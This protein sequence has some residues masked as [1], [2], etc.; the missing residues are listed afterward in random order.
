MPVHR[1]GAR[2]PGVARQ[3]PKQRRTTGTEYQ[4]EE[5]CLKY[6]SKATGIP[7][8]ESCALQYRTQQ[9]VLLW[10]TLRFLPM[11]EARGSREG[12]M[13]VVAEVLQ[14]TVPVYDEFVARTEALQTV[15]LR[16]RVEGF[17]EQ[18]LFQDGAIVKEGQVLCV[19]ERRPYEAALQTAKA[20]LAKA[21]ADL[22][23]AQEQVGV[24]SARAD[25]AQRQANLVKAR[26]DVARLRPLARDRAVPQQDLDA[27]IA[28]E[29]VAVA[30][31]QAAEAALKNAEIQQRV[32]IRQAQAAVESAKAGV[33]QAELN[34]SYTTIRAPMLGIIGFLAVNKGNLVGPSQN[35][36][37]ATMSSIDPMQATFGVSEVQYLR[38]FKIASEAKSPQA[39]EL[40]FELLLADDSVYPYKGKLAGIDR[41]V[42]PKTGTLRVQASFPNP[43]TLLRP[44]QFGRVRVA[45]EEVSNALLVPQTAVQEVQGI[46]TVL[47]VD[48]DNKAALRTITT[49]GRYENYYVRRRE[50]RGRRAGG[51]N[52][53]RETDQRRE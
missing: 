52:T 31:V 24:L 27:A 4:A 19:I 34:L 47:V 14:K 35:P 3:L 39:P 16:A 45:A 9:V 38:F 6:A 18:V 17:L 21:E 7:V 42:D 22:T 41:A 28:Q 10:S 11:A 49:E 33:T 8:A 51:G 40:S 20:Q 29:Q 30:A 44:G 2:R 23:Q 48:H 43:R 46:R 26:Q 13:V 15:E 37:L 12:K 36:I 53:D 1:P 32:G 50:R 5:V 25:L